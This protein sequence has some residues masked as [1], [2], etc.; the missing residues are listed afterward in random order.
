MRKLTEKIN[1]E[2][3]L[4]PADV[5]LLLFNVHVFTET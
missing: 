2:S 4:N 1:D 3:N 5:D